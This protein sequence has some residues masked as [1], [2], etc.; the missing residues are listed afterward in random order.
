[1]SHHPFMIYLTSLAPSRVKIGECKRKSM[2]GKRK[3]MVYITSSTLHSQDRG[4]WRC[5]VSAGGNR[6]TNS[7]VSCELLTSHIFKCQCCKS[8]SLPPEYS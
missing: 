8:D 4:P 3:K 1:M 7:K 2:I 5:S 6:A